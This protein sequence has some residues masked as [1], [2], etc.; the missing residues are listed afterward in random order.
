[1]IFKLENNHRVSED[2]RLIKPGDTFVAIKGHNSD[3]HDFIQDAV[4]NGA[5][6][7]IVDQRHYKSNADLP[8]EVNIVISQDSKR[9]LSDILKNIYKIPENIIG[10]TGTNG[11]TS[12]AYFYKQIIEISGGKSSSIGT[13]G[14]VSSENS[15]FFSEMETLTTP[16]VS[17]LYSLLDDLKK[18]GVENVSIEVSSHGL[19][20]DRVAGLT[21]NAAAFTSF[22]Q[23]HLDYHGTI[24]KYFDAKIKLFSEYLLP[25]GVAVINSDM[26]VADKTIHACKELRH[27]VFTYGKK[28]S[29]IKIISSEFIGDKTKI[30]FILDGEKVSKYLSIIG[31]FQ[32][33]N[34]L[35]ALALAVCT[36]FDKGR[37][38]ASLEKVSSVPGR[39]QIAGKNVIVDYAHTDDALRKAMDSMKAIMKEGR[40]IVVFGCGGDRDRAKRRLMGEVVQ[41]LSD[42]AIVTDDN[43]RTE[44]P[45]SIRAEIMKYCKGAIEV[46]GRREA[47]KKA[48]E[49]KEKKDFV[50][51]AGKGHENYQILGAEKVHFDD[52][53]TAREFLA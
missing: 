50:L 39:M 1:V 21:F 31:D 17:Q 12:T 35:C 41:E 53:E 13:L 48:I 44:S 16:G 4:K 47:I 15:D 38:L 45:S 6:T 3:G 49:M 5:T 8:K 46:D 11:K 18:C 2:S 20:Q 34:L 22:S 28:G 43:P 23:D 19:D 51:I 33:E 36:G 42:I 7:I 37:C 40:L 24:D 52:V 27:K 9:D 29:F 32:V 25:Q 30:E 26:D 10:I 14:V